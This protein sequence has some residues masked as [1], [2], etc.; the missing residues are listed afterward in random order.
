MHHLDASPSEIRLARPAC[1]TIGNFD[2]VHLGHQSLIS[3]AAKKALANNLDLAVVTFW[4]HPRDIIL[5]PGSHNPLTSRMRRMSYLREAGIENILEIPFTAAL[6][7]LGAEDFIRGWLLP[8][9]LRELVIGHDFSLGRGRE[10][11]SVFLRGIAQKYGFNVSQAPRFLLDGMPVS[12]T[13]IRK[14]IQDGNVAQAARLLGHFHSVC[15][16]VGHG[17]G[18]GAGIGFPTANLEEA[19]ALLPGNGVYACLAV[20]EDTEYDAVVNIGFNPTFGNTARTV[21][22]HLLEAD[23]NLYGG[24]LCLRFVELLRHERKF[25]SPADLAAQIG[26]DISKARGILAKARGF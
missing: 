26:A 14:S 10:G 22:T 15:G 23:V 5:G 18:R 21:E 24:S 12:S 2:G 9:K 3:L 17:Y 25:A 20:A 19:D 4:P 6:A 13:L 1:V 16:K 8:L 11:D 7:S